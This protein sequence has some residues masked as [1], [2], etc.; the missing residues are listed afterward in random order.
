MGALR[1]VH[2]TVRFVSN[3]HC[4]VTLRASVDGEGI[5]RVSHHVA[6]PVAAG[7]VNAAPV[8]SDPVIGGGALVEVRR[9]A[10]ALAFDVDVPTG[11][12]RRSRSY[13]VALDI[14][15]IREGTCPLPVPSI[16]APGTPGSVTLEVSWPSTADIPAGA[17]P[18]VTWNGRDGSARL[19]HVP[20]FVR[21][22]AG[23]TRWLGHVAHLLDGTAITGVGVASIVWLRRRQRR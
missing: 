2:A 1:D 11:S 19:G 3:T 5:V 7:D 8:P 6:L 17:F 23:R 16:P 21:V 22:F 4:E 14:R 15:G 12:E 13:E 9:Q 18:S 10:D 20:A